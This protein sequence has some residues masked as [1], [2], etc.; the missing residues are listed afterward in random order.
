MI[1]LVPV[2]CI[3]NI[4][5]MYTTDFAYDGPFFVVLLSPPY[6]SSPVSPKS[7]VVLGSTGMNGL[8]NYL[9]AAVDLYQEMIAYEIQIDSHP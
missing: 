5:H 7:W 3:S 9:H 2:R 6:P 1:D 4:R 8:N